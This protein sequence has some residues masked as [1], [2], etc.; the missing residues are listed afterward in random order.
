MSLF[1]H[2]KNQVSILDVVGSYATLKKAGLYYKGVCPFHYEKTPSFTVS[3]H[4]EIFYCFGCHAGGDVIEF[5]TK[6]E[7]CSPLHAAKFLA[8][9]YHLEIP[10]ELLSSQESTTSHDEKKRYFSLM[11]LLTKWFHERLLKHEM[12]LHYLYNRGLNL[13]T[14]KKF[15]LGIYPGGSTSLQTL[16]HYVQ[17]AGYL[18]DDLL[19]AHIVNESKATMYS[20]F[21]DRIMFPIADHLGNICGFGGRI[22]KPNDDRPKYVNSRENT[23]FSKGHLLFGFDKA[24]PTIQKQNIAYLVE[25]YT[26]CLMM[27]QHGF[28]HTVATLGTACTLEH[29]KLL[30]RFCD[31]LHV[32]YDGDQAGKNAM[33]RLTQLCWQ[34]DLDLKIIELPQGFDPD[35]FLMTQKNL[36]PLIEKAQDIFLFFLHS[37]TDQFLEKTLSQK[38]EVLKSF[39]GVIAR[40]ESNLKQEILLRKGANLFEIPY[41]V[42]KKEL[43]KTVTRPGIP[44]DNSTS[45]LPEKEPLDKILKEI[46]ILEK[47]LFSA[48][49]SNVHLVSTQDH[50][51]LSSYLS[52]PLGELYKK[53]KNLHDQQNKSN[54]TEFFDVLTDTEKSFVSRLVLECHD[55]EGPENYHYLLEHFQKKMWKSFVS[56]TKI[57]LQ[58]AR[59]TENHQELEKLMHQFQDLKNRLLRKG[60]V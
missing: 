29:L 16:T 24:K 37:F 31:Q 32:L 7:Q 58:R 36:A 50:E 33:L 21:E 60:L 46:P 40:L 28:T 4:K 10:Q 52:T 48:I 51:Y 13:E 43:E 9:R 54:F 5:I 17:P 14:I 38:L 19:K 49:V 45:K 41:E 18:L 35:S 59:Q 26:D 22:F 25:G 1:S 20:P 6:A 39:L 8:E 44:S 47:K 53:L 3:P 2:I 57:K 11:Q 34:V 30:A 42:L 27:A 12:G 55:Y 15:Q 56:D 23:F